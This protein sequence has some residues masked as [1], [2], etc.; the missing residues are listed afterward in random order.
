MRVGLRVENSRFIANSAQSGGAVFAH[1]CPSAFSNC[2]FHGNLAET[3]GGAIYSGG[4]LIENCTMAYNTSMYWGSAVYSSG[5]LQIENSIIWKNRTDREGVQK[6]QIYSDEERTVINFSNLPHLD[7]DYCGVGNIAA[8]PRF[9]DPMG[10][11]GIIG[12][13]DDELRLRAGSPCVDAGWNFAVPPDT[14]DLD[15]DGDLREAS[16]HD[17]DGNDR[18]VDAPFAADS[19]RGLG[20]IVD[21]GAYEASEPCVSI[22][23]FR[24][25]CKGAGRAMIIIQTAFAEGKTLHVTR[26]ETETRRLRIRA[27]GRGK[28]AW[29]GLSSLPHTFCV[30]ECKELCRAVEC[31]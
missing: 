29:P 4:A 30:E 19:G 6:K 2:V 28:L 12:T 26:D 27:K 10:A 1:G 17:L 3:Y 21:M 14:F 18:F 8:N 20:P 11:D 23:S 16:P 25:S 5:G 13:E 22:R 24:A 15:L 9:V 7:S 31:P